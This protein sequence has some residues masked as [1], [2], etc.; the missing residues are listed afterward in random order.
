MAHVMVSGMTLR[1]GM[2]LWLGSELYILPDLG[3]TKTNQASV[4]REG[5]HMRHLG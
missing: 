3:P 2:A 4:G 1:H 5:K